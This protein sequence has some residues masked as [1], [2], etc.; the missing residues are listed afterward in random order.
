[1]HARTGAQ[2]RTKDHNNANVANEW[3]NYETLFL[4]KEAMMPLMY[5]CSN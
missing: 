3:V 4:T 2:L 1:M 5:T